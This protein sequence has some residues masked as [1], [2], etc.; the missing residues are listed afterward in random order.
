M[1]QRFCQ[2][3]VAGAIIRNLLVFIQNA[4]T[5]IAA[6]AAITATIPIAVYA[7]DAGTPRT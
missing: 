2:S 4:A 1:W 6:I 5:E 3:L 7:W